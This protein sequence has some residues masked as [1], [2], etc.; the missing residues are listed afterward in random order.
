MDDRSPPSGMSSHPPSG[1]GT[2]DG[3]V[4]E[5]WRSVANSDRPPA[6]RSAAVEGGRAR[7]AI[8][9]AIFVVAFASIGWRLVSLCIDRP[10]DVAKTAATT[11][12]K[13]LRA[14][15]VDR[16]GRL[17]ARDLSLFDISI[18]PTLLTDPVSAAHAL[19]RAVPSIDGKVMVRRLTSGRRFVYIERDATPKDAAA[20]HRLGLPGTVFTREPQRAYPQGSL[21]SHVL[22]YVNIDNH[23][24]AG[25]ELYE[26]K[27]LRERGE[28]GAP[29]QLS[30]DTDVQFAVRDVLKQGLVDYGAQGAVGIVLNVATGEVLALVSVPDFDPNH[31]GAAS[32]N[33]RRNRATSSLYEMGS[34]FKTF[35]LATGFHL[36]TVKPGEKWDARHPIKV[37]GRFIRDYYP[38]S[39]FLTTTEV[40]IHSSNIGAAEMALEAGPEQ[41]RKY[42]GELGMLSPS[43]IELPEVTPP[44]VQDRWGPVETATIAYGYGISVSPMQLASG[45]MALV[46]G[47]YYIAPTLLKRQPG[48][49]PA[50]R[51]VFD[52]KTSEFLRTLMRANVVEGTG[53]AA[54]VP[55]YNVGGKTGTA[56]KLDDG[57][58]AKHQRVSSFVSIFPSEAPRYLVLVL[59]DDPV[60]VPGRPNQT[61]TAGATAAPLSGQI[62][63]RIAPILGLPPEKEEKQAQVM[64][65]KPG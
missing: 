60:T 12:T 9:S 26:D 22:G 65:Y 33:S 42:L 21:F 57:S 36:G 37:G 23:G 38:E 41:Q 31:P 61:P 43:P 32:A 17:L 35:T 18:N 3:D 11:P 28:K 44:L 34:T 27:P 63:S 55:G 8:L 5:F 50:R 30:L 56:E 7:L 15:I 58:Y 2:H 4:S 49:V 16:D 45:V 40:F 48:V 54:N 14:D 53:H 29:L 13:A 10:S 59:L 46:N 64:N 25:L 62:I 52:E 1:G 47:G 39:R 24:I 51:Q 19:A 20:V 6:P